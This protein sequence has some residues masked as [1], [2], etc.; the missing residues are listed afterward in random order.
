MK[1]GR[2]SVGVAALDGK[3]HAIGGRN[4]D[5]QRGRRPHEVYD[6]AHQY[7]DADSRRCRKARDHAAT[8][9]T[10][11]S[12]Y[13][14]RRTH[15]CIDR[16]HRP[17]SIST[18]RARNTWSSG[19][20]MPTSRS[21]LAGTL[22]KDLIMV[23]GGEL[24]HRDTIRGKRSIRARRPIAGATLAPM[25][26]G[27]HATGAATRRQQRLSCGRLAAAGRRQVTERIDRV[28]HAVSSS[29]RA[30]RRFEGEAV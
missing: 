26:H 2:G 6:P 8:V 27:R 4:P 20:P 28:Y 13:V 25:P 5:G 3:I 10:E 21:G 17:C 29:S 24:P 30:D 14:D 9:A 16:P 15:R 7:L 12:I 11:A 1:A 19:P 23:L 18:I 22:Y